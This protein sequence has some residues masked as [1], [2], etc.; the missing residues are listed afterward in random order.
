MA[1]KHKL[2]DLYIGAGALSPQKT[3]QAGAG[4]TAGIESLHQVQ[5]AN[6]LRQG[7]ESGKL[8]ASTLSSVDADLLGSNL[9]T[10]SIKPLKPPDTG[11]FFDHVG[12]FFS[13]LLGERGL[14]G[15]LV[16]LPGGVATAVGDLAHLGSEAVKSGGDT[17]A[18]LDRL[19]REVV[20]P[21]VEGYKYSYGPLVHGNLGEFAHRFYENPLGPVLDLSSLV[22]GGLTGG[23]RIAAR[24]GAG[25]SRLA[26]I[27][28]REGRAPVRLDSHMQARASEKLGAGVP[29][30]PRE[31]SIRPLRHIAQL[32][33]D[34]IVA[35]GIG[36]SRIPLVGKSL[37]DISQIRAVNKWTDKSHAQQ[38]ME[39]Q[40]RA[41]LA[42]NN[43][44]K[45]LNHLN[46]AEQT[47][48][49]FALSGI[50]DRAKLSVAQDYWARSMR[51]EN[52]DGHNLENFPDV[53]QEYV[54]HLA[55]LPEHVVERIEHPT[56]N[57]VDAANL[58]HAAVEEGRA[59][60]GI[61][62]AIHVQHTVAKA[63]A[64]DGKGDIPLTEEEIQKIIE[65]DLTD[66]LP[67]RNDQGVEYPIRPTYVPDMPASN[68]KFGPKHAGA[69]S[70]LARRLGTSGKDYVLS[71]GERKIRI[72]QTGPETI[73][74]PPF[75]AYLKDSDLGTFHAGAFR[76]DAKSLIDH[77][78]ARE[79]DLVTQIFNQKAIDRMAIKDE[80]GVRSF[81]S[82][83]D[84]EIPQGYVFLPLEGA[85]RWF[86]GED[87]VLKEVI[88]RMD[89]MDGNGS[90][91]SAEMI[92]QLNRLMDS[93][94]KD[95]V[96]STI[97][98]V[99]NPGVAVPI[100]FAKRMEAI[101]KSR[102]PALGQFYQRALNKWR[103]L[104]LAYMPR[105]WINTAVGSAFLNMV[106]GVWNPRDYIEA[107]RLMSSG[108][109]PAGVRL[110][111]FA[112]HEALEGPSGL[113]TA[114]APTRAIYRAVENLESYFRVSSF[115]HSL[116][117]EQR[118]AMRGVGDVLGAYKGVMT[119]ERNHSA[120]IDALLENPT[121]VEHALDDV[122]RFAYNMTEL[123]PMERKYVRAFIPFWGWYKFI[124]KLVWRLPVEFPGRALALNQLGTIGQVKEQ[125]LG[126]IPDWM[127]GSLFLNMDKKHLAFLPTRG[128]NP[129]A[130]FA[131]PFSD[132]GTIQGLLKWGQL[133]PAIQAALAGAG[134]DT[135]TGAPSDI[136]PQEGVGQDFWGNPVD[137]ITGKPLA[138]VGQRA[139]F[140]RSV[141]TLLRSFPQ[142]R[143]GE[144]WATG[145]NPVYPESIPFLAERPKGVNPST[146]RPFTLQ[147]VLA[148][149][150][151]I[152]PRTSNLAGTQ[153]LMAKQIEYA[154]TTNRRRLRKEQRALSQP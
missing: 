154:R 113:L 31:Y 106:K 112:E 100:E 126:L 136:S 4:V 89:D 101:A 129:F 84:P 61:D 138:N 151:G 23:A 50:N 70:F 97:G 71:P 48:L 46:P 39:G 58:W 107:R 99:K 60:L 119:D 54:Q 3:G 93:N 37:R 62:P 22:S 38:I 95:F 123:G 90:L 30:I 47:A 21:V 108:K 15:A 40:M 63:R 55:N 51:G 132:E 149:Y 73:I 114:R 34:R 134:L 68:M 11:G 36:E 43:F 94:A 28:S 104:T 65:G 120:Y 33:G 16:H 81:K 35:G 57:M 2:L 8:K 127:K 146:R 44:V 141:A 98:A 32:T 110:G 19:N 10:G 131:N 27:I 29:E 148:Q 153:N 79:S 145:G 17:G 20:K 102:D 24:V 144:A 118:R 105:W 117:K 124:T 49:H 41:R 53:P 142:Y 9:S 116:K 133:S 14:G 80:N 12:G 88:K 139:S 86:R 150:S 45:A 87:N 59:E 64:L 140:R 96:R 115:V 128:L 135:L 147:G 26:G 109:L 74:R 13:H 67:P 56:Q 77:I 122:N 143:I 111:G 78:T 125:E 6:L 91:G 69:L 52:P 103:T 82:K 18:A 152:N 137:I 76:T 66:Y 25:E 72:S 121:L 92:A 7:I 5:R 83:N 1:R 42:S 75:Q 85:I 130:Q